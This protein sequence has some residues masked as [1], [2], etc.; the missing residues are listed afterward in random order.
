MNRWEMEQKIAIKCIKD[1]EFKKKLL[2]DPKKTLKELF[3]NEKTFNLENIHIKI[4]Q[5][6]TSEWII[7]IPLVENKDQLS[8]K[9]LLRLTAG[10]QGQARFDEKSM[11]Y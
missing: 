5:E 10:A 11:I 1:P 3:K 8:E 2:K 4:E 9:D 6:K 7:P